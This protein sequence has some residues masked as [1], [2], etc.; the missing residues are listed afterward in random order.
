MPS[1]TT[2]D[3][4]LSVQRAHYSLA[5]NVANL[6]NRRRYFVSQINSGGLLYPGQPFNASVTV[7]YR[8][9]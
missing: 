1:R 5:L 3:G 2:F 8:F 6:T 7:R 4:S 9:Q